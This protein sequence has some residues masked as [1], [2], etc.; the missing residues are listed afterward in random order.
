MYKDKC[1]IFCIIC[2]IIIIGLTIYRLFIFEPETVKSLEKD[3]AAC[4]GAIGTWIAV[5]ITLVGIIV[6]IKAYNDQNKIYNDNHIKDIFKFHLEVFNNNQNKMKLIKC[7]QMMNILN[8]L[9][10]YS[11]M[12]MLINQII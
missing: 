5:L 1:Q 2:I 4:V 8:K 3:M 12:N 9:I 11:L 10:E 6:A 7:F